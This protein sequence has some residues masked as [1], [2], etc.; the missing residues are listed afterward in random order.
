MELCQRFFF[1]KKT[2]EFIKTMLVP[3]NYAQLYPMP[4]M[5]IKEIGQACV[6]CVFLQRSEAHLPVS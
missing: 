6:V 2:V 5:G 4:S 1:A 3:T